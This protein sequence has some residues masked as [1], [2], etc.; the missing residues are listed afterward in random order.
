MLHCT[1]ATHTV[2]HKQPPALCVQAVVAGPGTIFCC[3]RADADQASHCCAL[4]PP[5]LLSY[6][7]RFLTPTF[8]TAAC[9]LT[10]LQFAFQA[11]YLTHPTC[12]ALV[13]NSF[14]ETAM[15]QLLTSLNRA[16]SWALQGASV[17]STPHSPE[18][19]SCGCYRVMYVLQL[20]AGGT[21]LYTQY[22]ME[23][24][25]RQAFLQGKRRLV[26]GWPWV[27]PL[28][29]ALLH[30]VV[31]L[32]L[33]GLVWLMAWGGGGSSVGMATPGMQGTAAEGMA[34]FDSGALL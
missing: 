32:Q 31:Y 13:A 20:F 9:F 26:G 19:L 8:F 33:F 10:P 14:G 23:R 21:L 22:R 34:V 18:E 17:R 12:N 2:A 7:C 27:P 15:E 6:V 30:A 29:Q 24:A 1:Q 25:N 16:A 3:H 4:M 28:V 11:W 5:L